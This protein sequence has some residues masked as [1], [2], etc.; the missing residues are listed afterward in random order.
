MIALVHVE[1]MH[2]E[3]ARQFIQSYPAFS[4]YISPEQF[5][6]ASRTKNAGGPTVGS[7]HFLHSAMHRGSSCLAPVSRLPS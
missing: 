2:F 6:V 5:R 4:G 1:V 3:L 7:T